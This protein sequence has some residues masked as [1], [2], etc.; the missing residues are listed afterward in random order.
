LKR[1]LL[2]SRISIAAKCAEGQG[3]AGGSFWAVCAG[4]KKGFSAASSGYFEN[5]KQVGEWTTVKVTRM[6]SS[7]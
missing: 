3:V 2:G 4:E 7:R 6:K 5:G 1:S